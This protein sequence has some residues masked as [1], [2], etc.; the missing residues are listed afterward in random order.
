MSFEIK[1]KLVLNIDYY[2]LVY[3]YLL[4]EDVH[5]PQLP[6]RSVVFG[7]RDLLSF[8]V[9]D[10]TS[11]VTITFRTRFMKIALIINLV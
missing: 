8:S 7:L 10:P 6:A 9:R 1:K 5:Y 2:L 3:K 4:V 11:N